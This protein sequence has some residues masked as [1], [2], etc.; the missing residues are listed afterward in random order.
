LYGALLWSDAQ[1]MDSDSDDISYSKN[2]NYVHKGVKDFFFRAKGN[3]VKIADDIFRFEE[4]L[5]NTKTRVILDN[6]IELTNNFSHS[7]ESDIKLLEG[8][9]LIIYE[10]VKNNSSNNE[11]ITL[12][13]NLNNDMFHDV[14]VSRKL[15]KNKK[16]LFLN[17]DFKNIANNEFNKFNSVRRDKLE[18]YIEEVID[19]DD[20]YDVNIEV[21]FSNMLTR[22]HISSYKN[23]FSRCNYYPDSGVKALEIQREQVNPAIDEGEYISVSIKGYTDDDKDYVRDEDYHNNPYPDTRSKEQKREDQEIYDFGKRNKLYGKW[24]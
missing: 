23:I 2:L 20:Y 21:S 5:N 14:M 15:V 22:D 11:I 16:M 3:R 9:G 4:L 24:T 8:M 6:I 19:G 18:D 13:S 1:C 17:I 7:A 10:K 12:L